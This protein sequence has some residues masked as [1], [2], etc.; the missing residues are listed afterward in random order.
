MQD[1]SSCAL[2]PVAGGKA[3]ARRVNGDAAKSKTHI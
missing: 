1:G 3:E 2:R